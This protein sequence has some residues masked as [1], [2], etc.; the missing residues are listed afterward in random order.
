[1]QEIL[2]EFGSFGRHQ[3]LSGVVEPQIVALFVTPTVAVNIFIG[4]ATRGLINLAIHFVATSVKT[5][6][7]KQ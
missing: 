7:M 5:K 2:V 1:L 3:Q 6:G 4:A